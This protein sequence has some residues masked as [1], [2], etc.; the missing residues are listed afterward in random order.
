MI[1]VGIIAKNRDIIVGSLQQLGL[2]AIALNIATMGLGYLAAKF[3]KLNL[4]QS[5]AIT[6]ESGIQNGTLAIVIATSIL[7]EPDMALPA[8]VYSLLMFV[9]GGIIMWYFGRRDSSEVETA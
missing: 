7:K 5:L 4:A 2:V 6:I 8:A 9:T 1:L 3:L